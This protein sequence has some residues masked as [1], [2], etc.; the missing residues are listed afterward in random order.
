MCLIDH[1]CDY[2][3]HSIGVK[4][5]KEIPR[6]FCWLGYGSASYIIKASQQR[7]KKQLHKQ[8]LSPDNIFICVL[9]IESKFLLSGK[10]HS[11]FLNEVIKICWNILK[12]FKV[13]DSFL[14]LNL[15][16]LQ[17]AFIRVDNCYFIFVLT[18][19]WNLL[20][21]RTAEMEGA[22]PHS[23]FWYVIQVFCLP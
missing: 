15:S 11:T 4:M 13:F 21:W 20:F 6:H 8:V 7:S 18:G 10:F 22:E 23:A 9:N 17:A 1:H 19:G 5:A 3:V 12:I 14:H 2:S 16:F